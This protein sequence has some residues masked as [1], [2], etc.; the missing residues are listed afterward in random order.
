MPR[1]SSRHSWCPLLCMTS[2]LAVGYDIPVPAVSALFVPGDRSDQADQAA[3]PGHG[4]GYRA[5]VLT[6]TPVTITRHGVKASVTGVQVISVMRALVAGLPGEPGT[7]AR[8][9][10]WV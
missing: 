6:R 3:A 10:T 2:T 4:V 7:G 9:E 1:R 8:T 5:W